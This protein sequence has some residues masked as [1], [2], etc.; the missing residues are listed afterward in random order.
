MS[1]EN[2]IKD[3]Y[4][5]T[6]SKHPFVR[7]LRGVSCHCLDRALT[8]CLGK[9]PTFLLTIRILCFIMKYVHTLNFLLSSFYIEQCC[10]TTE[11]NSWGCEDALHKQSSTLG[12]MV[13]SWQETEIKA[14]L[15]Q[16]HNANQS[17]LFH[18][19]GRTKGA[20]STGSL[21][22]KIALQG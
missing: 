15:P 8:H 1:P 22:V 11:F 5:Y 14:K 12:W 6:E 10:R 13:G 18:T 21:V 20:C 2:T 9:P 7:G 19:A 4:K 16:G 3:M 17:F